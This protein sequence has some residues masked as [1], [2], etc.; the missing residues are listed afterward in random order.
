MG[1]KGKRGKGAGGSGGNKPAFGK[2][3]SA[4]NPDR[5]PTGSGGGQRDKATI[6]RLNMYRK[7]RRYNDKGELVSGDFTSRV[8]TH[9]AVIQPDRRWFGNTRVVGQKQLEEF[10]EELTKTES[11]PYKV[12]MQRARLPTA[13]ITD[14]KPGKVDV[15]S[16]QSY[17]ETFGPKATRKRPALRVT[18]LEAMARDAD[19]RAGK[20]SA[21]DDSNIAR[22]E[23]DSKDQVHRMFEKGQSNR[24]WTELYKVIDSSDVVV[25]VL[26]AR[27]PMGTRSPHVENYLSK[28]AKHK[29]LVFVLN[30]CDLVPTWCTARWVQVLSRE[31][32]TLAFHASITNPFGKGALINLLRQ[33]GKLHS[34]DKK[35][36][37][38]GFCGYPNVGKSSIINTLKKK[39]VCNVA[40]IPG[41]TKVWQYVT[42]FKRVYLI[43]CP[44]VVYPSGDSEA[45]T[46]LKGVMRT[47]NLQEPIYYI[48]D[49]LKRAKK[50]HIVRTYGI[51]DWEDYTDF[52]SKL[53]YKSGRLLKKGEPDLNTVAK[54]IIN[55]W[56]R[57]RIPFFVPPPDRD[58]IA[59]D[60][61][62]GFKKRAREAA[63]AEAAAAAAAAAAS[64]NGVG[65]AA[66]A[67]VSTDANNNNNN[68]NG[69]TPMGIVPVK[70]IF[71]KINLTHGDVRATAA[72]AGGGCGRGR[73]A[74]ATAAAA[75]N[76]AE[77][78]GATRRSTRVSRKR[79]RSSSASHEGGDDDGDDDDDDDDNNDGNGGNNDDDDDDADDDD[80]LKGTKAI[81]WNKVYN[82][83][84]DGVDDDGDDDDDNDD[85]DDADAD[86]GNNAAG[87]RG[88]KHGKLS[89]RLAPQPRV[90]E[91]S[92]ADFLKGDAYQSD[93]SSSG[94]PGRKRKRV[95]KDPRM[96]T[97][98]MKATNYY[99]DANVKNRSRRKVRGGEGKRKKRI[100]K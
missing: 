6:K 28:H 57:G 71:S 18:D 58:E 80:D 79:A 35:Q 14:P 74:A 68:N 55:D 72:A 43:D 7:K 42:L 63:E 59:N 33:F 93:G 34:R 78:S 47:E 99:A 87:G 52:V 32:P 44:G 86:G 10:R 20:Y 26:D 21:T 23:A 27:D 67:A 60:T 88:S 89:A 97:S 4:D 16:A 11:D 49:V 76:D 17:A 70:Q 30:K 1:I 85:D 64:A 37:S 100:C 82:D 75:A 54:M 95:K 5:V 96:T 39:K 73:K 81:N 56:I 91:R 51:P 31:Y 15:L 3:R 62:F 29:H 61:R 9:K 25:Q 77:A 24:I 13:L 2:G 46:V 19:E 40:P 69:G 92:E 22:P 83:D 50:D 65:A 94:G 8:A 45:D 38:V 53:A 36:I 84:S 12:V 90:G 41:E 98:K 48:D 66:A